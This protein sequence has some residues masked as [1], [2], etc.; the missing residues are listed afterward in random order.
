MNSDLEIMIKIY[1]TN[2]YDWLGDE[3]KNPSMLT[4]H[5]IIKKE[6][7]GENGIS[8]YAL[9]TKDSHIFI[10]YLEEHFNKE[11]NYLNSKRKNNILI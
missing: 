4:R 5:H 8:N 7:G 3:I 9:L 1:N 11:Y 6:N 10:H 2:E